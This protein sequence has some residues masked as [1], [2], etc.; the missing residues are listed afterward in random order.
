AAELRAAGHAAEAID[1]LLDLL[2][3]AATPAALRSLLGE[4]ADDSVWAALQRI[5]DTVE[6]QAA[7][8]FRLV[9]DAAAVRGVGYY[10]GQIFEIQQG[11]GTSSI[12]GGG[13]YDRMIGRFIGRDIP[14][15]GFS[16]GFERVIG[17]LVERG[18]PVEG[19]AERVVLVFD[20]AMPALGPVLTLAR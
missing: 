16:I 18:A 5:L 13:R 14:A 17:L 2:A 12:A 8:R 1:R 10:T 20:E 6:T 9:F 7:G 15:T 11:D 4:G 3:R 19:E